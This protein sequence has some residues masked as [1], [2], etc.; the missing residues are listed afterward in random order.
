M[1]TS[2]V[3]IGFKPDEMNRMQSVIDAVC[4]ELGVK[5]RE[6]ARRRAV[7]ERVFNAYRHGGRHP[8]DMVAAGLAETPREDAALTA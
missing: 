7:A 5:A 2:R 3:R 4:D 6:Q 8:L 1:V